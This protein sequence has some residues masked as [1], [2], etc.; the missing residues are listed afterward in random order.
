[1]KIHR[2]KRYSSLLTYFI[3]KEA[4]LNETQDARAGS[5]HDF[6]EGEE[7]KEGETTN[8]DESSTS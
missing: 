5:V 6:T 8:R 4:E 1:L 2:I 7:R 3:D